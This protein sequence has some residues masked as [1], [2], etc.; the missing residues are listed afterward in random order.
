MVKHIVMWKIKKDHGAAESAMNALEM[1]KRLERLT[2]SIFEIKDL[3]VGMN[4]SNS[5]KSYDIVLYTEFDSK[6][7][8]A[9]Y[10]NHPEHIRVKQYIDSVVEDRAVV[11]F[12]N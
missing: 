11:D 8:L 2:S 7:D 6:K 5:D 3:E 10:L 12:E 4:F 1:K 9:H